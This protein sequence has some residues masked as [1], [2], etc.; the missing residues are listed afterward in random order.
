MDPFSAVLRG[1][2]LQ[3]PKTRDPKEGFFTGRFP[4]RRDEPANCCDKG[5]HRLSREIPPAFRFRWVSA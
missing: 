4:R 3:Y 1:F 5:W 2:T